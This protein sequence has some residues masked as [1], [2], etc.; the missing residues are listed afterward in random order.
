MLGFLNL[1]KPAGCSSRDVVNQVQALV[2]PEK[3]GHAGTLDPLAT[4]VLVVAVGGATRFIEYVQ[5]QPKTYVGEFLLGRQ[6]DTEDT[7]GEVVELA[8]APHPARDQ[9]E[10]VLPR[11][12]GEIEQ[13]PPAYSA[14]RI[15]GQRAYKRA[16][17][18]EEVVLAPRMIVIHKLDLLDYEYPRFQLRIECGSGTYVRSLGRDI[19]RAVKTQAVM[20]SLVRT[21]IGP[22]TIENAIAGDSL[23]RHSVAAQLLPIRHAVA[24]LPRIHIS[25]QEATEL[26]HGRPIVLRPD[27]VNETAT[28]EASGELVATVVTRSGKLWPSCVVASY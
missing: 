5:Q 3:T 23:V 7:T 27:V 4:G 26:R 24:H 28:L 21:A 16:R 10:S 19:A 8:D 20:S 12:I 2:R 17:R 11:F 25:E 15:A 9:I 22:F 18:G 13:M 6:S 1:H 14:L